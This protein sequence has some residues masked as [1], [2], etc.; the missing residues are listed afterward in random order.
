MGNLL[1]G[2]HRSTVIEGEYSSCS[3]RGSLFLHQESSTR[4]CKR[5]QKFSE[6]ESSGDK[7]SLEDELLEVD[8]SDFEE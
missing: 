3:Q 1:Q 7:D 5:L 8:H 2:S 6:D 4:Q